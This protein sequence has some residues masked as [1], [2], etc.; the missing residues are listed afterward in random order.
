MDQEIQV[1]RR[2][3]N[4]KHNVNTATVEGHLFKELTQH[5]YINTVC[6][7]VWKLSRHLLLN[8]KKDGKKWNYQNRLNL[9]IHRTLR[10]PV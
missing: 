1:N 4:G 6:K 5:C 3:L 8:V 7:V 10:T 2:E 9:S